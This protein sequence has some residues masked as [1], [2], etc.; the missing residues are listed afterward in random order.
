MAR[1]RR[2]S[3]G[4]GRATPP[5]A[6][7]GRPRFP[8]PSCLP[9]PPRHC[10]RCAASPWPPSRHDALASEPRPT[11]S[12]LQPSVSR[13]SPPLR[14]ADE[15][16][17]KGSGLRRDFQ[18]ES[19]AGRDGLAASRRGAAAGEG[20][21]RGSVWGRETTETRRLGAALWWSVFFGARSDLDRAR[22]PSRPSSV[23]P[24]PGGRG[25][26]RMNFFS[27]L[28][29]ERV[30]FDVCRGRASFQLDAWTANNPGW[31]EWVE[32]PPAPRRERAP[33]PDHFLRSPGPP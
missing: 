2:R 18:S 27:I 32:V 16:S 13:R 1:S 31:S 33:A 4:A 7:G 9:G 30:R 3:A 22:S 10:H 24:E 17:P 12:F 28:L 14:A 25:G 15:A 29:F 19:A 11:S 8:S 5:V 26:A 20:C 23:P 21:W 6:A